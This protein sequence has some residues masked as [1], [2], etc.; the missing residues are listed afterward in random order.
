MMAFFG[1]VSC[2]VRGSGVEDIL[3]QAD[4]CSSGSIAGL[5]CLA[6]IIIVTGH[7]IFSEA[8]ERLFEEQYI[9]E[10]PEMLVKFVESLL[11][12]NDINHLLSDATN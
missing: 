3:F 2:F 6:N 10:V 8:L 9:P 5:Y 7:Y 12:I 11:G 4:L 1:V